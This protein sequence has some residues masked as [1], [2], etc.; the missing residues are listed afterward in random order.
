VALVFAAV[1]FLRYSIEQGWL[2]PPIR[3]AIGLLVGAGLLAGSEWKGKT[4]RTT[5]NALDAA[6]IAILFATVFASNALWHLIPELAT[7]VLMVL[8]TAVAVLLSIR[9]DS[10]F[11]ALLG[12]VGGYATPILLSTGEN[13]PIGLFSYLFILNAGLAWVAH[14]RRWPILIAASVGFTALYQWGWV[15]KFVVD[16]PAE[17]PLAAGV[18]LVFPVLIAVAQLLRRPKEGEPPL[19]QLFAH[20]A[21]VSVSLPLVFALVMAWVPAFGARYV[22]LFGYLLL[23]DV[24]LIAL[25]A[26]IGPQVLYLGAGLT[27]LLVFAGW[28]PAAYS[29]AALPVVLAFVA[30]FVGLFLG[31]PL[32]AGRLKRPF[33]E[34]IERGALAAPLLL[35]VFPVLVL[36]D[37]ATEHPGLLFVV[38]F[39][40]VGVIGAVAVLTERGPLHFRRGLLRAG[41]RGG[42]VRQVP[43]PSPATR[44]P[45]DVRSVRAVLP[46]RSGRGST[47]RQAPPA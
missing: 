46:W 3:M 37:P 35:F 10:I 42:L 45:G 4:I 16:R 43:E 22:L 2:G 25:A 6:G 32:L 13:R 18:F 33:D 19:P 14:R 9:H 27:T 8:I 36:V 39:I 47:P 26:T 34:K 29:D 24:G 30:L 28:L 20:T 7:F 5:A 40:L 44:G 11:V 21:T 15:V 12:L 23:L 1:F 31:A 41:R 38:L 17:L